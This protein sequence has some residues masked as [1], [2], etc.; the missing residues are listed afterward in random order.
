M[1]AFLATWLHKRL[2]K[3]DTYYL[4]IIAVLL[5]K[6]I[7]LGLLWWW[8]FADSKQLVNEAILA[9]KLFGI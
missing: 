5:L 8:F 6:F 4:E 3:Q 2:N 7:L 1:S 9:N